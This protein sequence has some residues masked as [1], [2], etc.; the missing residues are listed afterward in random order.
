MTNERI[1]ELTSLKSATKPTSTN[2]YQKGRSM[3]VTNLG[4]LE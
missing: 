4:L 2:V 1:K 3:D